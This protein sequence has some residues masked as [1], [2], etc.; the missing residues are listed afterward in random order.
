VV[1]L[2]RVAYLMRGG[3]LARVWWLMVLSGAAWLVFDTRAWLVV[4]F[5]G[6]A[7]EWLSL[8]RVMRTLGLAAMGLAGLQQRAALGE[9]AAPRPA[10]ALR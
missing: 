8:L 5:P 10:V 6:S 1:P 4:Y 3:R 2:L 9:P 7:D